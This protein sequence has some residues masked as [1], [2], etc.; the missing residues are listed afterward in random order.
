M[1]ALPLSHPHPEDSMLDNNLL[2]LNAAVSLADHSIRE[3]HLDGLR[4][5]KEVERELLAALNAAAPSQ[6]A[7]PGYR[8]AVDT[9]ADLRKAIATEEMLEDVPVEDLSLVIRY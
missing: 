1:N 8:E 6:D 9:L 2:R 7:M 3:G 5:L 4:G